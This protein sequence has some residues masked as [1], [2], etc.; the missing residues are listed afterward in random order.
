MPTG[1]YKELCRIE[2]KNKTHTVNISAGLDGEYDIYLKV[3]REDGSFG[4]AKAIK[5]AV[6][7]SIA[8]GDGTQ[9]SPYE[10][11]TSQQ[12]RQIACNPDKHYILEND[13]YLNGEWSGIDTLSGSLNGNG[14]KILGLCAKTDGND[15]GLFKEINE[16]TVKNLYVEG[17]SEANKNAGLIA[18]RNEK[19]YIIETLWCECYSNG[20]ATDMVVIFG[21]CFS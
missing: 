16:G 10:I 21:R 5:N 15:S 12:L 3:Q 13:I 18:G 17:T 7:F 1:E 2:K 8:R 19:G 6:A 4:S 20:A 11:Y 9:E 14:Y